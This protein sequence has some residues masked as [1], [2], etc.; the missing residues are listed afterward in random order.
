VIKD[1][2]DVIASGPTFYDNSTYTDA[3]AVLKKYHLEEEFKDVVSIFEKG[4][5][6]VLKKPLKR[7]QN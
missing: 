4:I 1:P 6:G 5:A 2:L 3:L 7:R